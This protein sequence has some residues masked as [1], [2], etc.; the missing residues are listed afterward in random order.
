MMSIDDKKAII[1]N[2][3]NSAICID[4]QYE[5]PYCEIP[6]NRK[7]FDDSKEMYT[8]F[9]RNG[10]CNLDI[11]K[12]QGYDGFNN[13][14]DFLLNHKDLMILDWE[15]DATFQIKHESALKILDNAVDN[16][17][18]RWVA[19]YTNEP[20]DYNILLNIYAYFCI[21]KT[22]EELKS[23]I[24]TKL[25]EVLEIVEEKSEL[26][27]EKV[28]ADFTKKLNDLVSAFTLSPK[29]EQSSI[30]KDFR[31]YIYNLFSK[32]DSR[33]CCGKLGEIVKDDLS[34]LLT[35]YEIVKKEIKLLNR[36]N[37]KKHSVHILGRS[38]LLINGTV[39]FV[40]KKDITP[41]GVYERVTDAICNIPN[42]RT[43]LLSLMLKNIFSEELGIGGKG[44]GGITDRMLLHHWESYEEKNIDNL[45]E[46]LVLCIK[47]DIAESM[48][49]YIDA[50]I[51][52]RLFERDDDEKK[53]IV[54]D[55]ELALF[56]KII[57][58]VDKKK[59]INQK[60]HQ[61]KTGDIFRLKTKLYNMSETDSPASDFEE[62]IICVSQS[63]DCLRPTKIKNNFAFAYGNTD[64]V[65]LKTA[66]KDIEKEGNYSIISDKQS[67][68]W[69]DIFITIYIENNIF[70]VDDEVTVKI[71]NKDIQLEYIG[72]LK[73]YYAQR[74]VNKIF[75]HAL[76]IGVDLPHL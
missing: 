17:H 28:E 64:G 75:N 31:H 60:H 42:Q 52:E 30:I 36:V 48:R 45:I 18:I 73:D 44:L 34:I 11:Y 21:E 7:Y 49:T 27:E 58:F 26:E 68:R 13:D 57:T 9:R 33:Q 56:N 4:D 24:E 8:S 32:E 46:F 72:G 55:Y 66:L 5:S 1:Y 53:D 62:Y 20:N 2:T 71:G 54:E 50:K 23:E 14:K 15:L 41:D 12:F 3:I 61:I 22:F 16:K 37:E 29:E 25:F 6:E 35:Y 40:L 38:Y 63:C 67:I 76:R 10:K 74:I 43:L 69:N 39:I 65:K 59:L 51:I 47:E 70:N 19:I